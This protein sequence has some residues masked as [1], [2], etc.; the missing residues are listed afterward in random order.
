MTAAADDSENSISSPLTAARLRLSKV[1]QFISAPEDSAQV[2][3]R[4]QLLLRQAHRILMQWQERR[5]GMISP[6]PAHEFTVSEQDYLTACLLLLKTLI[7]AARADGRIDE[8]EHSSLYA[9]YRRLCAQM[10]AAG[11]VDELLTADPEVQSI[12]D[13]VRYPEEALDIYL[14]SSLITA[15]DHFLEQNYLEGLA[16]ALR[17]APSQRRDLDAR[18]AR[19]LEQSAPA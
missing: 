2:S 19:L 1:A 13:D 8:F 11:L 14:L 6:K 3:A 17:I 4:G 16:A 12:A 15:G 9:V 18:A 10:D 7:F 5:S